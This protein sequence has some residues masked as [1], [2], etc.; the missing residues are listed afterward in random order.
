MKGVALGA[1]VVLGTYLASLAL[2]ALCLVVGLG[3]AG[4]S[5]GA[6]AS[7]SMLGVLLATA[8]VFLCGIY[9]VYR[10]LRRVGAG[11]GATVGVTIGYG[12]LVVLTLLAL[13]LTTAVVFNR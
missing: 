8:V 10:G 9:V 12:V 7:N 11:S 5:L 13:A 3:V 2:H 1:L 6:R 4:K